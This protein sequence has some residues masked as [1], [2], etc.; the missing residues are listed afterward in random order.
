MVKKWIEHIHNGSLF[1]NGN[2]A[3][4]IEE[5]DSMSTGAQVAFLHLIDTAP[6]NVLIFGTTNKLLKQLE[7]RFQDRAIPREFHPWEAGC[8]PGV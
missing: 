2:R 3:F 1:G 5:I 8:R 6:T 7:N 4:I